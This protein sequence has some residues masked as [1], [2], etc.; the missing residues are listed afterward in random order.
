MAAQRLRNGDERNARAFATTKGTGQ[1]FCG[2][3]SVVF[4]LFLP[5]EGI[6]VSASADHNNIKPLHHRKQ[7]IRADWI[8]R[9]VK[10]ASKLPTN[11]ASQIFLFSL[12]WLSFYLELMNARPVRKGPKL[13]TWLILLLAQKKPNVAIKSIITAWVSPFSPD[14]GTQYCSRMLTTSRNLNE[15]FSSDNTSWKKKKK[16]RATTLG[17]G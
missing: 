3:F 12:D 1:L 17:F 5:P 14:F 10:M 7:S 4:G 8:L 15:R 16:K 6:M 13:L 9:S 2:W 11:H